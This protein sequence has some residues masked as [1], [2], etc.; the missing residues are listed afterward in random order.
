MQGTEI[1]VKS[2][3]IVY[4]RPDREGFLINPQEGKLKVVNSTAAQVWE[5]MDDQKT[6]DEIACE[7]AALFNRPYEEVQSDLHD[8]LHQLIDRSLIYL[9]EE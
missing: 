2:T 1:P 7:M 5:L 9:K 4:Q 6:I 8:F 3:Q